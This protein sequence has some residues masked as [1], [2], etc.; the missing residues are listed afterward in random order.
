M[1]YST[2]TPTSLRYQQHPHRN[3]SF[4]LCILLLSLGGL[5]SAV[6]LPQQF[7]AVYAVKKNGLTIGETKRTLRR[8]G[9]YFQFESITRPKGVARLFTSGQV[10]ERSLWDFFQGLPRPL[11]YT[12]FN[13]GR[14]KKRNV[15]L[16]FDWQKRQV[17]NT[18]NGE[19]WKMPLEY[20][21]Q[22]KLLYQLRIMQDLPTDQ[23]RLRYPIADGGKLKY[24]DIEVMG[25]ERIRTELGVFDAVR[26]RY[27][28]GSRKTTM[29][30]ARQL[31]YLPVRIEQ[32]KNNDSPV[33]AILT[34]VTGIS[35]RNLATVR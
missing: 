35:P 25:T 3:L 19:P 18:I 6:P 33:R 11:K 31:S 32:Q 28:K 30:C 12:Y 14:K 20:G 23:P 15:Q 26:L 9:D 27:I 22:D 2:P 17:I 24:Y 1:S 34:S 21:T 16:D 8:N 29:W 5:A 7:T 4:L 13:S 10:V